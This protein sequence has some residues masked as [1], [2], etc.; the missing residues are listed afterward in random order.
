MATDDSAKS[1]SDFES[2]HKLLSSV[3]RLIRMLRTLLKEM[4]RPLRPLRV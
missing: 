2:L 1:R 3:M 4:R